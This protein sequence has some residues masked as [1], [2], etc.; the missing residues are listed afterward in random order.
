MCTWGDKGGSCS[1][2]CIRGDQTVTN[3]SGCHAWG[4]ILNAGCRV[5]AGGSQ[6][7]HVCDPP[8]FWVAGRLELKEKFQQH[9]PRMGRGHTYDLLLDDDVDREGERAGP[10][11]AAPRGGEPSTWQGD[12]RRREEGR[13]EA[14]RG[15]AAPEDEQRMEWERGQRDE[16]APREDRRRRQD[17]R[18][19]EK[20]RE[21]RRGRRSR[22]R[23]RSRERRRRSRSREGGR[24]REERRPRS[25][26]RER[27]R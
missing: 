6:L 7:T 26:S 14:Q 20:N 5:T 10:P 21:G 11:A 15:R 19:H 12:V 2:C 25:R 4:Y 27:R 13:A 3:F 9:V 23:E 17:G 22:S 18:D 8:S 16:R 24:S 1:D